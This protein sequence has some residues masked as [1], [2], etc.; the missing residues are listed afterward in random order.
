MSWVPPTEVLKALVDAAPADRMGVLLASR[1]EVLA[2]M[3]RLTR[4]VSLSHLPPLRVR[5]AKGPVYGWGNQAD[6]DPRV[7]AALYA[8]GRTERDIAQVLRVGRHRVAAALA[9]AGVPRRSSGRPLPLTA[10]ELRA[11]V[12]DD[13]LSQYALAQRF[14]IAVDTAGRWLADAG[15]GIPDPR[16]DHQQLRRLYVHEQLSVRDVA[17][18][19]VIRELAVP[20]IPRRSRHDRRPTG[21]RA[22]VTVEVLFDLYVTQ[23]LP[24]AETAERLAV[25]PEYLRRRLRDCGITRRPGRYGPKTPY[26]PFELGRRAADLYTS[27]FTMAQVAAELNVATSTVGEASTSPVCR[28]GQVAQ[29][30]CHREPNVD[31]STTSTP[32]PGSGPPAPASALPAAIGARGRRSHCRPGRCGF[33]GAPEHDSPLDQG[34]EGVEQVARYGQ[35]RDEGEDAGY[36]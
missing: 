16:I 6:P 35:Q 28:S 20:R 15:L 23:G 17:D 36:S 7:V 29:P 24:L 1:D 5:P 22:A 3:P 33:G 26:G 34:N 10:S 2:R 9:A 4:C 8:E 14:G 11:L 25:G 31:S 19:R 32:T 18:R 30:G 12:L 27:G 21:A 13:G